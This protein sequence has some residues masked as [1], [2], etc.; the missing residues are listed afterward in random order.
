VDTS[1]LIDLMREQG[2]HKAGAAT[3]FL[4]D[5]ARAQLG[6]SVFVICELEAGAARAAR[7]DRER[8][9]VRSLVQALTISYPDERFALIYGEMLARI[10]KI[11]RTVS[12]MD[13]LIATSAI[14]DDAEFV[15]A[16]QKHFDAIPNLR[17]LTYR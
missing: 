12:P 14:V 7:P 4:A 15:S 6:A 8:A 1:F 10:Q 9:R 17:L 2:R 16:N 11:G 13:L 3:Q 5:H